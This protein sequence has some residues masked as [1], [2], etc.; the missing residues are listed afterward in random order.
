MAQRLLFRFSHNMHSHLIGCSCRLNSS[1]LPVCTAL[2]GHNGLATTHLEC[3]C[4]LASGWEDR[5]LQVLDLESE[6]VLS[7]HFP[8][9]TVMRCALSKRGDIAAVALNNTIAIF[10]IGDSLQRTHTLDDSPLHSLF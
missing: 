8:G 5:T 7:Q 1:R 6:K 3:M 4:L 2:H 10:S 9:E